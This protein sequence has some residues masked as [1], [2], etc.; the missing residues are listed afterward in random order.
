MVEIKLWFS[1]GGIGECMEPPSKEESPSALLLED[2]TGVILTS[3]I[4]FCPLL[5]HLHL[6]GGTVEKAVG[7]DDEVRC[8][9]NNV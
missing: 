5:H 2:S 8:L 3:N 1:R 6:L 4:P 9:P 7:L